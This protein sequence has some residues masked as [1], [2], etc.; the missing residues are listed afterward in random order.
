MCHNAS[1]YRTR[2][3]WRLNGGFCCHWNWP[4]TLRAILRHGYF[5]AGFSPAVI[6]AWKRSMTPT[7]L[8][9]GCLYC[10][11]VID[12]WWC[13]KTW[14]FVLLLAWRRLVFAGKLA[15]AR[16]SAF[17]RRSRDPA[18]NLS[19]SVTLLGG[20]CVVGG[21]SLRTSWIFLYLCLRDSLN[22]IFASFRFRK[23]SKASEAWRVTELIVTKS[24][25]AIEREK[26]IV[27]VLLLYFHRFVCFFGDSRVF[28]LL[29]MARELRGSINFGFW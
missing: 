18:G 29:L 23:N 7:R 24:G 28:W 6:E 25:I 17:V 2:M 20:F 1:L 15:F 21:A 14:L 9:D 11:V 4:S 22:W 5:F 3:H 19:G 12:V 26:L 10:S 16:A 8:C 13:D 27:N